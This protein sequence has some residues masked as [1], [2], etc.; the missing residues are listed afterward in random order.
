MEQILIF[1][2]GVVVATLGYFL[3]RW[4]EGQSLKERI[5]KFTDLL[6]LHNE[7][8]D[9]NISE[10][11]LSELRKDIFTR[12]KWRRYDEQEVLTKIGN[13]LR[14]HVSA[15][16]DENPEFHTQNEMNQYAFHLADLA[17]REM[18]Y[19][20]DAVKAKLDAD[21]LDSFDEVQKAWKTFADR[22]AE[23]AS[24][25]TAGGTMQSLLR[26]TAYR[27]LAIER[28]AKLKDELRVRSAIPEF[29][30]ED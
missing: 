20:V 6:H 2:L 12:S 16:R 26:A 14:E 22:Q 1:F 28:A 3:K 21:E 30:P 10:Q 7:L 5:R 17:E 23:F 19:L 27:D 15:E 24:L 18:N 29:I 13:A 8:A 4:W 9:A 11:A 25:L